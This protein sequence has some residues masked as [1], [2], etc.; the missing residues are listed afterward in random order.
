VII[1]RRRV[2]FSLSPMRTDL[3]GLHILKLRFG[4]LGRGYGPL[5]ARTEKIIDADPAEVFSVLAD[6][7]SYA[8]WV[9]GSK[10]IRDADSSWPR[11]GSKF[12]HTVG[13]GPV[14]VKDYSQVEEVDPPGY[15]QLRVKARPLGTGRVKLTLVP[16][17]GG[18]THVTM[19]EDGADPATAFLFN[20]LT[21]LLVRGR[22]RKTLDRLAELA[23]EAKTG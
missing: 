5:V 7:E 3:P 21:H 11:E 2:L 12:H 9:V 15:L 1:A 19:V 8:Y 18:R 23:E 6:P 16:L 17:G 10:E 20:P 13:F 22:N 4:L 14:S